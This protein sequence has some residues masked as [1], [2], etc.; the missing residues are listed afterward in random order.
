MRVKVDTLENKNKE[1]G[2]QVNRLESEMKQ[3]SLKLE[4]ILN[5]TK[6]GNI[7]LDETVLLTTHATV[8]MFTHYR[9]FKTLDEL[10]S[11]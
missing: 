1:F 5:G 9:R 7:V 8:L 3:N 10:H 2:E 6:L 4:L 11:D